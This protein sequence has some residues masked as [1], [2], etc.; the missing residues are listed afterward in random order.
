MK[1]GSMVKRGM[2]TRDVIVLCLLLA[3][4]LPRK[5]GASTADAG[6]YPLKL[7][8]LYPQSSVLDAEHNPMCRGANYVDCFICRQEKEIKERADITPFLYYWG[9]YLGNPV[10]GFKQGS[11]WAQITV[12]G[13]KTHLDR[14]GLHK[15]S[16]VFSFMDGAGNNLGSSIG[17]ILT[18]AQAFSFPTFASNSLYYRQ[19]LFDDEWEFRLGRF[20]SASVF[21]SLPAMGSLPVSGAVNGTP[22][23]LF[24]NVSGWHSNGRPS[25]GAYSKLQTTQDTFWKAAI[26]EVNPLANNP[27]YHGFNMAFGPNCG[28]LYVSE[29]NWTPAFGK[30]AKDEESGYPGVY[31]AGAYYQNYPQAKL[32]GGYEWSTYGFYLQGQQMIW[33]E[34]E[35]PL[36]KN[37]SFWGGITY[38][39]QTETA[40]IPV[41][42][43]AGIYERGLIPT[44]LKDISMLNFYLAGLSDHYLLPSGKQ[45]T[46]ETVLEASHI[47]KVTEHLQFQPD[48]QWVIQPG[49]NPSASGALV[50]GFQVAAVF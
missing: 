35:K 21:A 22:A 40:Q 49:G 38:S 5:A 33:R 30:K 8:N 25:W 14:L 15:G 27:N 10:G 6:L 45:G 32:T 48:V 29:I 37:I 1:E 50:I 18:P 2:T 44:R 4:V 19:L 16:L 47:I 39:P 13:A 9:D 3:V 7:S 24:A 17:N 46:A 26:L 36:S 12:F 28:S 42:G 31:M 23:S 43:Y 11:T 34:S 20:S 41:M